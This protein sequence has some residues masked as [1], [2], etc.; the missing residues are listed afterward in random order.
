MKDSAIGADELGDRIDQVWVA[1]VQR[2]Y[3]GAQRKF[4]MDTAGELVH[5]ISVWG[6]MKAASGWQ[7]LASELPAGR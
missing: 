3:H 5:I 6:D 7:E 2:V 4:T 1:I